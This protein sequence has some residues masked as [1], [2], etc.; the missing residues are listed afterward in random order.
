M[1]WQLSLFHTITGAWTPVC[2]LAP[3]L[4]VEAVS[5]PRWYDF[6]TTLLYRKPVPGGGGQMASSARRGIRAARVN[7]RPP[8]RRID[9]ILHHAENVT[10]AT[11]GG[12]SITVAALIPFRLLPDG[13]GDGEVGVAD[14]AVLDDDDGL[15]NSDGTK[16]V[17]RSFSAKKQTGPFTPCRARRPAV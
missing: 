6:R 17:A 11:M 1:Y 15:V 7:K 10:I 8:K 13:D 16:W 5:P 3:N 14:Q 9:P 12:R 4:P 2:L